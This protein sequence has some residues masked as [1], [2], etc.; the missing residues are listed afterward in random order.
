MI[1]KN[2]EIDYTNISEDPNTEDLKGFVTSFGNDPSFKCITDPVNPF[3]REFKTETSPF[4]T[5]PK[6]QEAQK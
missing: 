5:D 4:Q 6:V 2:T 3:E 1:N